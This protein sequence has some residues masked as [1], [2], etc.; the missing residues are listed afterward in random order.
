MVE[1]IGSKIGWFALRADRVQIGSEKMGR[2]VSDGIAGERGPVFG[3][4]LD[5]AKTLS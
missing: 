1:L 5:G 4:P 3:N 2:V